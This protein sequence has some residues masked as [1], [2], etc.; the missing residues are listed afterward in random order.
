MR[1]KPSRSF[2]AALLGFILLVILVGTSTLQAQTKQLVTWVDDLKYLQNIPGDELLQQKEVV[3]HIRNGI[4]FWIKL[5]PTTKVELQAAPP[6]PWGVEVVRS[7]VAALLQTSQAIL[8]EDTG[9]PFNLGVTQISVTVEASPLSP[10]SD[11]INR[12]E[13]VN[14]QVLTVG[15]ALDYLPGLSLDRAASRN[16]AQIRLRGFSNRGQVPLYLDGIPIQVPYDGTIDFN[17]FLTSDIAEIQVAKGYSSP[18]L[19]PNALGGSINLV[20]RQPEKKIESEALLG[21]GSGE[22][23]L[24]SL[25]LG[26]RIKHFYVQGS[27][28]WLQ[29][30]FVPLSGKFPLQIAPAGNTLKYRYQTTYDRNQSDSRDAK[31]SGRIAFTPK[32][33]EQYVF[34]YI[35]QKGEKGNPLYAGPNVSPSGLRYWRWPY[36]NK[37]SYYFISNTSLGETDSIK[38]RLFYDQFGN[39][40]A[41]LDN[42]NFNSM[43]GTNSGLSVYK[44]HTGGFST[45]FATRRIRKNSVS[46]SFFLKD[47]THRE[48]TH[49]P[50]TGANRP[51]LTAKLLDRAQ[52]FSIGVQDIISIT[53][54]LR[55]TIGFSADYIKGLRA[56]QFN[57][58]NTG[59]LPYTCASNPT[60]TEFSGC[61]PHS[62]N[63]NP[64]AS[65]SYNFTS[66]DTAFITFADRSRFPLL[67]EFYSY[68]NRSA[69]PNPEL[70]SEHS[71]NL[72]IGYSRA[73]GA[74]T[75][76]QIQYFYNNMRD[77]IQSVYKADTTTPASCPGSSVA[78]FCTQNVNVAKEIHKGFE[79]TLRSTPISHL[80][81]DASYAY[82]NREIK[83]TYNASIIGGTTAT[84]SISLLPTLPKN[85]VMFNAT[86]QLPRRIL[87]LAT[88]K[89]EGGLIL[90]DTTYS[91]FPPEFGTS[92]GIVDLGTVVPVYAGLSFQVGLKN[93]FDRNYCFTAGYPE[94]GRNWYF[95]GRYKF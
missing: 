10:V 12:V 9:Q 67:K 92:Y 23:L 65:L 72:E 76:A 75:L 74:R 89:Y 53:S 59:L 55:A 20:T 48:Y 27:V 36:W 31:Y 8:K 54:K 32:G 71:S 61:T 63:Y 52:Q 57:S 4:E 78:G 15:T 87:G 5:H 68:R 18:L 42:A 34:S 24:A 73:F 17:R 14:R 70:K 83:F 28:D 51:L 30:D 62:W 88:Y 81:V 47:D 6:E 60:N 3:A 46:A 39:G 40:L 66:K 86:I 7:Q 45:E 85:K 2:R 82:L 43:T 49:Y 19:G 37:N 41:M 64:Q 21:T 35:N 13:I 50:G 93:V 79:V 29:Q 95:N 25:H 11:S 16:E 90:Q 94:A 38:L 26:S 58:S 91:P 1:N 77:A 33:Q 44:D 69:L 84:N 22:M 56:T 80:T